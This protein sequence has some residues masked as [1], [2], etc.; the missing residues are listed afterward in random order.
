MRIRLNPRSLLQLQ[1]VMKHMGETNPTHAL[2]QM[3]TTFHKSLSHQS[4]YEDTH[5]NQENQ[6][7]RPMSH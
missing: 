2:Q 6:N 3:I 4:L 7:L 5:D 1:K